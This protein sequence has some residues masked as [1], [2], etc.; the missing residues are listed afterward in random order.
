M[1][2]TH[3]PLHAGPIAIA[4]LLLGSVAVLGQQAP[5]APPVVDPQLRDESVERT[6]EGLRKRSV[7][8]GPS[9]APTPSRAPTTA[10]PTPGQA[11]AP[12]VQGPAAV[13]GGRW[14]EGAFI[15][16]RAGTLVRART[17]DWIY[18]PRPAGGGSPE[19]PLV[20]I[21]SQ[22]LERLER[23]LDPGAE[24]PSVSISGQVFSYRGRDYLLAG[25][26]SAPLAESQPKTVTPE[27]AAAPN[28]P[29]VERGAE[30]LVKDL[31]SR[32]TAPRALPRVHAARTE[33]AESP[34][35][36]DTSPAGVAEGTLITARRGRLIRLPDGDL[37]FTPDNDA[38]S[39]D[40]AMPLAPCLTLSR[41]EDVSLWRGDGVSLEVSGRVLVYRGRRHLLPTMFVMAQQGEVTPLQ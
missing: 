15:S 38:A 35:A 41:M 19:A 9:V 8:G 18:V 34:H 30:D 16:R 3:P 28:E 31:E 2:H 21:P 37:A 5:P 40:R 25:E 13:A 33:P 26:A 22:N 11:R 10:V 36:A 1:H 7:T 23:A 27:P 14:R 32:T 4:A 20:L 24:R 39:P 17:G 12:S 6:L 29:G